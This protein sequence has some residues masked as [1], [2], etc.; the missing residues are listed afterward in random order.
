MDSQNFAPLGVGREMEYFNNWFY[1]LGTQNFLSQ[2]TASTTGGLGNL[3][4]SVGNTFILSGQGYYGYQ[5]LIENGFT[6]T[7][8][9]G[10]ITPN[11]MT[12]TQKEGELLLVRTISA[13]GQSTFEVTS[14]EKNQAES[15]DS[16][17]TFAIGTEVINFPAPALGED[18]NA[19]FTADPT[20]DCTSFY[21]GT[22]PPFLSTECMTTFI[23]GNGEFNAGID[24][25]NFTLNGLT[26][27]LPLI[28]G[29]G[30]AYGLFQRDFSGLNGNNVSN[31]LTIRYFRI[32][33][34][35]FDNPLVQPYGSN[36]L[37]NIAVNG[38]IPSIPEISF[39]FCEFATDEDDT[40]A[41]PSPLDLLLPVGARCQN[42][43]SFSNCTF[44][45]T[46]ST[47]GGEIGFNI[48]NGAVLGVPTQT[49]LLGTSIILDT[50]FGAFAN[51]TIRL[52][53]NYNG[54]GDTLADLTFQN[55][56][57]L[58]AV[59]LTNSSTAVP[60][61]CSLTFTN[62]PLLNN[63]DFQ[64]YNVNNFSVGTL[65]LVSNLLV[66]DNDLPSADLDSIIIALDNNGLSNGTFNY[67]NQTS[68]SI[69]SLA[70]Q[71]AYNNLNSRGWFLIGN[72][73]TATALGIKIGN[74]LTN[75]SYQK[76][77]TT[78][79]LY[80]FS[81]NGNNFIQYNGS[82][83]EKSTVGK[84]FIP[85]TI[86]V[87]NQSVS[88]S[89]VGLTNSGRF[90]IVDNDNYL[91]ALNTSTGT[92]QRF[93]FG[94]NLDLSTL[95]LSQTSS[96]SF[97]TNGYFTFSNDGTNLFVFQSTLNP[98]DTIKQYTLSTAFDLTTL[99]ITPTNSP[100][101]SAM[102]VP[103]NFGG[104]FNLEIDTLG[105][106]I[107]IIQQTGTP[108]PFIDDIS[109]Y[110]IDLS[111]SLDI[112]TASYSGSILNLSGNGLSLGVAPNLAFIYALRGSSVLQV[113]V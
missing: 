1:E 14:A 15:V 7:T 85:S 75:S 96:I 31:Q 35:E 28:G 26:I 108:V 111:T 48:N 25:T 19:I 83:I 105:D 64:D 65:P 23:V 9:V 104:Y 32:N 99:N 91:F 68:G 92:I 53:T 39:Q 18:N 33:A 82:N 69:P 74:Y 56:S 27:T 45:Y 37:F 109:L 113:F 100:S 97:G 84:S 36:A 63:I 46:A 29:L 106:V 16:S 66:N 88:K 90:R 98:S 50:T 2:N 8:P 51:D 87:V 5:A 81:T 38:I 12:F 95:S 34:T 44:N 72:K 21:I 76:T 107:L 4:F 86:G 79:S 77:L 71:T 22:N 57:D 103:N 110:Q 112:T 102:G 73:P 40:S 20:L 30:D 49:A 54:T 55:N 60:P 3:L 17:S 70:S 59:L 42:G 13:I 47:F 67:I 52:F 78:N 6:I 61:P 43:I 62:N 94:T 101:L 89:S 24:L 93:D 41:S 58:L 11:V 10:A 80:Q